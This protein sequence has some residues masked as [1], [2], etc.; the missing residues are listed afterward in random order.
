MYLYLGTTH[1]YI[2]NYALY[3]N[4]YSLFWISKLITNKVVWRKFVRLPVKRS[5]LFSLH[6]V[7]N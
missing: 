2:P 3:V 6:Y 7:S 1:L 4:Y 5:E